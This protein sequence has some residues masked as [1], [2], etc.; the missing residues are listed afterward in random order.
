M[1]PI[2]WLEIFRHF[3]PHYVEAFHLLTLR[4]PRL[5]INSSAGGESIL[6][7]ALHFLN[8]PLHMRPAEIRALDSY[9]LSGW[10]YKP[11]GAWITAEVITATGAVVDSRLERR[12]SPDIQQGSRDP[13]ASNQRFLFFTRC[14]DDCVLQLRTPENE[15][16]QKTLA[17][18]RKAPIGFP[19]GEGHVHIDSTDFQPDPKYT[20]SPFHRLCAQIRDAVGVYYSWAFLPVLMIGFVIFFFSAL[21]Y[22]KRAI[23]NVCFIMA[24]ACWGMMLSLATLLVLISSTSWF[25][26]FPYYLAPAYFMMVAAAVLSI[27]AWLQLALDRPGEGRFSRGAGMKSLPNSSLRTL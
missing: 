1:P 24:F 13:D 11:K 9:T 26:L 3:L 7:P 2:R 8:Y 6:A 27:A 17:E 4:N 23:W 19:F 25:A 18:L 14:S 10:Y 20:R 5:A 21:A 12:G 16:I 15:T 22:G